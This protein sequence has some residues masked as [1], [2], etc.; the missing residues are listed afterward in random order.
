MYD[1]QTWPLNGLVALRTRLEREKAAG[2]QAVEV[3][4]DFADRTNT[5]GINIVL[6]MVGDLIQRE[7]AKETR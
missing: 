2:I 7:Q 3:K 6:S 4:Y 1:F 5:V